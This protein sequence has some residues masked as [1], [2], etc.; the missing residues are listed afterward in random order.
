[1]R[2]DGL[3]VYFSPEEIEARFDVLGDIHGG[4]VST[5]KSA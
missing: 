2:R 3:E 1:M 4:I 5:Y